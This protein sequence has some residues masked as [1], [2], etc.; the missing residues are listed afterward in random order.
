MSIP[1]LDPTNPYAAPYAASQPFAEQPASVKLPVFCKVMFI[2]SLVFCCL[3]V[4]LAML[5]VLGY[6]VLQQRN[7]PLLPTALFE[8]VTGA[9]IALFGIP[10]NGF[11]LA[12]KP[13]ALLLGYSTVA[14]TV[15]SV[16]VGIWQLSIMSGQHPAGSPEQMILIVGSLLGVVLRLAIL[17][18]YVAAL[19]KFSA[20]ARRVSSP[21]V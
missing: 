14:V 15:G 20:W 12:R 6:F 9:G 3:R 16:F 11:M 18:L 1:P 21:Q 8:I 13:W 19:V 7:D 10:A 2:I 17:G 5:S 4:P